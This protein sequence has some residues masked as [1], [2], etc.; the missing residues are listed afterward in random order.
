MK[1]FYA[2]IFDVACRMKFFLVWYIQTPMTYARR[3]YSRMYRG[4]TRTRTRSTRLSSTF[5]GNKTGRK[6]AFAKARAKPTTNKRQITK[7][8]KSVSTLK[9]F[10]WGQFQSQTSI[11]SGNDHVIVRDHPLLLHVNNCNSG[12]HGPELCTINGLGQVTTTGAVFNAY[13][14]EGAP[15][16]DYQDDDVGNIANGPILKH[17]WAIFDFKFTG[18]MNDCRIRVDVIRQKRYLTDFW[19]DE[20]T[21]QFLPHTLAS[22]KNLAGFTPNRIDTSTFQV[23]QTKYLYLNSRGSQNVADTSQDRNTTEATTAPTKRCRISLRLNKVYKQLDSSE[24]QTTGAED[25]DVGD[26]GV[27][28]HHGPWRYTNIH[29]LSNMWILLSSDDTRNLEDIIGG[30]KLKVECIRRMT[31]QDQKS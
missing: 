3:N 20:H 25:F 24:H 16:G 26:A 8:N 4:S 19:S 28:H 5:R 1:F 6:T 17:N 12:I 14:G 21:H 22:F 2:N 23:I 15:N 31:W 18:F 11:L 30:D 10:Q 13:Q 29:P 9:K 27:A 7:L